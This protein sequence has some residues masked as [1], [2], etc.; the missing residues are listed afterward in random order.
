MVRKSILVSILLVAVILAIA[1]GIYTYSIVNAGPRT[2][3][4]K[5]LLSSPDQY[6]DSQIKL[7][8]KLGAIYNGKPHF[9]LYTPSGEHLGVTFPEEVWSA[10]PRVG[11]YIGKDV[12]IVGVFRLAGAQ[13]QETIVEVQSISLAPA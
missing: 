5:E 12:E 10:S 7:T 13:A 6:R 3:T 11:E 8:G 1:G 9:F 2:V 4:V